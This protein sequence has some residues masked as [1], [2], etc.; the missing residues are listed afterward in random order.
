VERLL[1]ATIALHRVRFEQITPVFREGQATFVPAKVD[2]LDEAFVSE[3]TNGI[4]VGIEVLFG[5]DSERADGGQRTAVLAVQLVHT[6]AID[7]ELAFVATWKIEVV[8]QRV[9]RFVT[10]SVSLAV[11][12]RAD[13]AATPVVVL[14]RIVPSSVRHGPSF[15]HSSRRLGCP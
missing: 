12:S 1:D 9:T 6:V 8:K 10:V 3:L 14:A 13:V 5:Y 7:D 11:D 2:G 4:V 15:G